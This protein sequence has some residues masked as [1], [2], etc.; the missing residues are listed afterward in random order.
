MDVL[1]KYGIPKDA[2]GDSPENVDKMHR[3]VEKVQKGGKD[4]EAAIRIC[5]S[6]MFGQSI[7]PT[8]EVIL[9][10]VQ[11]LSAVGKMISSKNLS[12]LKQAVTV[13]QELIS[14]AEAMESMSISLEGLGVTI[15][16]E[17]GPAIASAYKVDPTFR[18]TPT[19]DLVLEAG[20]RLGEALERAREAK[21]MTR[22]ALE[23]KMP[24]GSD[25]IC[26]IECGMTNNVPD[27]ILQA[28]ADALGLD[29]ETLKQLRTLDQEQ[30]V[31][32]GMMM[33]MGGMY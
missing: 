30:P 2:G 19:G 12:A 31:G 21:F 24:I 4:K 6:S 1:A 15:T 28:F 10:Q 13:L 33:P 27:D 11:Y 32:G 8:E 26:Q 7:E 18:L 25:M 29:V 17:S 3:C 9:A 22:E 16:G 20:E 5:K 23:E 14:K